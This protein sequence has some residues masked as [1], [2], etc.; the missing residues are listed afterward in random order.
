MNNIKSFNEFINERRLSNTTLYSAADKFKKFGHTRLSKQAL[1]KA[2]MDETKH[3]I[4]LVTHE[5]YPIEGKD[6][7]NHVKSFKSQFSVSGGEKKKKRNFGFLDENG[8]EK[9]YKF[10]ENARLVLVGWDNGI[11]LLFTDKHED[12]LISLSLDFDVKKVDKELLDV[13][14]KLGHNGQAKLAYRKD[15][16]KLIGMVKQAYNNSNFDDNDSVRSKI[17]KIWNESYDKDLSDKIQYMFRDKSNRRSFYTDMS[18]NQLKSEE[19]V[20]KYNL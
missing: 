6:F 15:I 12:K 19:T 8:W 18:I 11:Q 4:N 10:V 20:D 9:R 14:F 3:S 16:P 7:P 13:Q 2:K 1:D 17:H 5:Y